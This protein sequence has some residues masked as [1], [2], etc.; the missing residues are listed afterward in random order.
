MLKAITNLLTILNSALPDIKQEIKDLGLIDNSH[1]FLN[2]EYVEGH[3]N[4]TSYSNS[5]IAFHGVNG[6]Y[7]KYKKPTK[8]ELKLNSSLLPELIRPGIEGGTGS[9]EVSY[10]QEALNSLVEKLKPHAQKIGF[11]VCGPVRAYCH[12]P[13]DLE[14]VLDSTLDFATYNRELERFKGKSIRHCLQLVQSKPSQYIV[15]RYNTFYQTR[16]G[17]KISPYNKSVYSEVIEHEI[18][19]ESLVARQDLLEVTHGIILLHATRLLG[20]QVLKSMTSSIGD[21]SNQSVSH[22]GIVIR[23][24][25]F[26]PYPFKLTGDFMVKG[27]SGLISQ[28]IKA[29]K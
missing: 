20:R 29:S 5:F 7:A 4:V 15:N 1:Y 3:T 8:K 19:V 26:S 2:T 14:S 12:K 17:K 11:D 21:L 24:N 9:V 10:S 28:K 6:F 27:M 22:E 18:P 23:D 25:A 16:E 13:I